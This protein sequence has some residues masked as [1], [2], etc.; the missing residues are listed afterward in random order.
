MAPDRQD[1]VE[2]GDASEVG[3][4]ATGSS[5]RS[6]RTIGDPP[7]QLTLIYG[8]CGMNNTAEQSNIGTITNWLER[9]DLV[10]FDGD[11]RVAR[12]R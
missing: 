7:G 5:G 11:W 12:Q 6:E 1:V 4:V 8:H 10:R 9:F 3:W 2:P